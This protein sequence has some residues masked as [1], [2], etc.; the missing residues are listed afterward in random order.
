M[1]CNCIFRAVEKSCPGSLRRLLSNGADVNRIRVKILCEMED[2]DEEG[3]CSLYLQTPLIIAC[4][5]S[6]SMVE[7]NQ[8]V[9]LLLQWGADTR[10]ANHRASAALSFSAKNSNTFT[11]KT[12]LEA[13]ADPNAKNVNGSAALMF[14]ESPEITRLLLEAGANPNARHNRGTTPLVVS[15]SLEITRLLLEAGADPNAKDEYG[16]MAI[17]YALPPRSVFRNLASASKEQKEIFKL[18]VR[19][20]SEVSGTPDARILLEML[21]DAEKENCRLAREIQEVLPVWCEH[22]ARSAQG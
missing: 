3:G 22:A 14:S 19:S 13:G 17:D 12:L 9:Q 6:T 1:S 20:G 2:E 10:V 18:L 7:A 11:T 5:H 8:C 16:K 15:K 4:S 21:R